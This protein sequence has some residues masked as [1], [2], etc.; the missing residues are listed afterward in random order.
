MRPRT[1]GQTD[2]LID[3][4]TSTICHVFLPKNFNATFSRHHDGRIISHDLLSKTHLHVVVRDNYVK[5]RSTLGLSSNTI[6]SF[7]ISTLSINIIHGFHQ[8]ECE[9]VCM[10]NLCASVCMHVHACMCV[11][12]SLDYF[13]LERFSF[14]M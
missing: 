13:L 11:R 5:N 14:C 4:L 7:D 12:L 10:C 2:G 3:L 6:M 8:C 9:F 1:D